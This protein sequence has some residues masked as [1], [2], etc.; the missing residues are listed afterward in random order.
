A[1]TTTIRYQHVPAWKSLNVSER[2]TVHPWIVVPIPSG[3]RSTKAGAVDIRLS[4]RDGPIAEQVHGVGIRHVVPVLAVP[5][6]IPGVGRIRFSPVDPL[7]R[8]SFVVEAHE[9][10]VVGV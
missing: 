1:A 6:N 9:G 5:G 8:A 4:T 2:A 3:C 7:E 10:I